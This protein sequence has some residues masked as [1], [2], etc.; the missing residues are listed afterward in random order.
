MDPGTRAT[1][2][3]VQDYEKVIDVHDEKD[4]IHKAYFM[5]ANG[6][7]KDERHVVNLK[8]YFGNN[9]PGDRCGFRPEVARQLVEDRN[10]MYWR[11]PDLDKEEND[12]RL[13]LLEKEL[14][15]RASVVVK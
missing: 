12:K 6:T 8:I 10:A 14:I 15:K 9:T 4:G 1:K 13:K 7:I 3:D 5:N 11:K 2:D